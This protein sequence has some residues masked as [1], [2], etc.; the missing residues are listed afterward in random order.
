[1]C[2]LTSFVSCA[3]YMNKQVKNQRKGFGKTDFFIVFHELI[4]ILQGNIFHHSF[5][6][7]GVGFGREASN[8]E[9]VFGFCVH[10]HV[11]YIIIIIIIISAFIQRFFCPISQLKALYK[12]ALLPSDYPFKESNLCGA[13]YIVRLTTRIPSEHNQHHIRI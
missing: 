3:I 13:A 5:I 1:M 2:D 8:N 7:Q 12:R 6:K 11:S 10:S 4:L 9:L